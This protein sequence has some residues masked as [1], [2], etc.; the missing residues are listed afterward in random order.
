M[1]NIFI[2]TIVIY[3]S[4][5][6]VK[7]SLVRIWTGNERVFNYDFITMM[8]SGSEPDEEKIDGSILQRKTSMIAKLTAI[9]STQTMKSGKN[10][11]KK[12]TIQNVINQRREKER[13]LKKEK[14]LK[15]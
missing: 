9:I 3:K 8:S 1:I 11:L 7:W 4:A 6:I 15:H 12:V 14:S 5:R 10:K 2:M 13:N